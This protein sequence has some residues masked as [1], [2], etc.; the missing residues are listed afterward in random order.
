M[1]FIGIEGPTWMPAKMVVFYL[2]W[3]V[4]VCKLLLLEA[5]CEP[6]NSSIATC[7]WSEVNVKVNQMH[8]S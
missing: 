1:Y 4:Q 2:L 5:M 8:F 7:K 6:K 3:F